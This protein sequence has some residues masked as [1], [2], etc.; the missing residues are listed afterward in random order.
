MRCFKTLALFIVISFSTYAQNF[1]LVEDTI[2][3]NV[4]DFIGPVSTFK[5]TWSAKYSNHYFC[6]FIDQPLYDSWNQK[7][8]LLVISE[9]GKK[10]VEVDL[11]N[12]FQNN[13]Y[14]DL[15]VRHDTLFLKPYIVQKEQSGYFFDMN[16]WKWIPVEVVSNVIYEDDLY[17]VAVIDAGEWG[18]YSWF[19]EKTSN[20]EKHSEYIMQRNPSRIIKKNRTYHFIMGN[21]VDTLVT[22]KGKAK[23]CEE[24]QTYDAVARDNYEYLYR[25]GTWGSPDLLNIIPVPSLFHFT[26]REDKNNYLY[27][28]TYDTIFENALLM[29]GE[30]FYLVNTKKKTYIAQLEGGKL[31]EKFNLKHRYHFFRRLDCFRGCNPAP[32]QCF[33]QFEEDKNSYGVLEIKDSLIHICHI[34][35]TQDSLPLIGTDNLEP[36]LKFLLNHLDHLTLSQTDSME[37]AL[38]G[39]CQG[40]FSK[41]RNGYFPKNTRTDQFGE[42]SY[43]TVIDKK[44]TLSVDYCV[45]KSDS[46]VHGV[47]FEWVNTNFYNSDIRSYGDNSN[48]SQKVAETRQIL[49]RLTSKNPVNGKEEYKSWIWK[50]NH[51]I[52]K[53]YSDGRMVMYLTE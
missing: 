6:I 46:I 26:G 11:P 27:G 45:H 3:I 35:H 4:A 13:Y 16:A 21:R 15:F 19:I 8:H 30:I 5:M 40:A 51:I 17:R 47:F 39:T 37:R 31:R 25:L 7:N 36:R 22:L 32:N 33:E 34:I 48:I 1:R 2:R 12:D 14:G 52:V 29:N 23:L 20:S 10:V 49:T 42:M 43:Y 28:I 18:S 53:L 41:L 44:K 50:L 24:D 38:R 9:D